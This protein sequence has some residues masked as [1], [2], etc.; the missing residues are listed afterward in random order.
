MDK[1]IRATAADGFIKMAVIT[2]RD[3][4][5]RARQIHKLSPTACAALGRTLCGASLLGQAMKEE[6]A[7]L[8]IRINGGGPMGSI[9]AKPSL[10]SAPAAGRQAGCGRR[11][12]PRRH[13]HRE[14]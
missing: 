9:V 4:V 14:P 13:A 11:G 7:S 12:R 5:E 2:A 3:T 8:T 10:R 1:T 6:K